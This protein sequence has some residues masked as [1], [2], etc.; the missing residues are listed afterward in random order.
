M[1]SEVA[2]NGEPVLNFRGDS[3]ALIVRGLIAILLAL[4]SGRTAHEIGALMEC[5][6]QPST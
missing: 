3:D 6:R 2:R 1:V 5:F 4:Y